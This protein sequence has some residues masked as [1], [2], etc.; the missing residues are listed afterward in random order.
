MLTKNQKITRQLREKEEESSSLVQK[1]EAFK[2]EFKK[3][4]KGKK[5][6]YTKL[7]TK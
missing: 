1:L 6:V 4:D 7:V 2:V 3:L 5:E